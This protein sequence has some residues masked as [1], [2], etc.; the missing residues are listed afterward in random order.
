MLIWTE[1]VIGQKKQSLEQLLNEEYIMSGALGM[2]MV[3]LER[4]DNRTLQVESQ[5]E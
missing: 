5:E 1:N 2:F 3:W 4:T